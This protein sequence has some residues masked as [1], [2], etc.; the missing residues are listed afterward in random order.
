LDG[1][2]SR[3][4]DI[5]A[6]LWKDSRPMRDRRLITFLPFICLFVL[7]LIWP[8]TSAAAS[9]GGVEAPSDGQVNLPQG[10]GWEDWQVVRD[11]H[12]HRAMVKVF[13]RR[14]ETPATAKVRV[15]VSQTPKPTF[16]S[17]QA[18][19]DALVQT[20]NHQCQKASANSL[21]KSADDLTYEMRAFGC[22]GQ[23]GER[24]LL[25]R[26]AFIGEW[27]LQVT[28]AP[29][30]PADNLPPAEKQQALRL[31]SSVTITQA[32]N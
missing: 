30:S 23:K 29:M 19:V 8:E 20:A 22:A 6:V 18:I 16:D 31:L 13:V 32:T 24:Y 27:E 7:M 5:A 17:P 4:M 14:G 11:Q 25:Q 2:V 3:K 21:R 9:A 1:Y 26:I 12:A 10:M 15:M 28:Y